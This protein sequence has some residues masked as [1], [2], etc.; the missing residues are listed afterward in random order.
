MDKHD[1]YGDKLYFIFFSLIFR[2]KQV[3]TDTYILK[4]LLP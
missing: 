1:W 4:D 2:I 3:D